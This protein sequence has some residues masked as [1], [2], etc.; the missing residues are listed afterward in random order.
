MS[1]IAEVL[2]TLGYRVSGSDMQASDSIRHLRELGGQIFIGHDASCSG[3][4]HV[5][6]VS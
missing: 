3:D 6:V 2:L 4:A 5:V 1:G